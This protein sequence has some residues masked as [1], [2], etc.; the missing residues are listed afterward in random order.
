MSICPFWVFVV[1]VIVCACVVSLDADSS[2]HCACDSPSRKQ[3][4]EQCLDWAVES[5]SGASC[6]D[7]LRDNPR[8]GVGLLTP[9][10]L[11]VRYGGWHISYF[12][13]IDKIV[14]KLESIS[15]IER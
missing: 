2:I 1:S 15:H 7:H 8:V 6:V 5:L 4:D 14:E 12:M 3:L 13:S 9:N 11:S 10:P